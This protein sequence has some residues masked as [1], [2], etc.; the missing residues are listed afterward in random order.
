[1]DDAVRAEA[2]ERLLVIAPDGSRL[3]GAAAVVHLVGAT[4]LLPGWLVRLLGLA[5]VSW[6]LERAYR[7]VAANRTLVGRFLFRSDR[8]PFAAP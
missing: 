2:A 7:W 5:P 4:G 8:G 1:M 6:V 3:G